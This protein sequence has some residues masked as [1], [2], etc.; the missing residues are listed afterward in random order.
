MKHQIVVIHG[1]DSFD[2]YE[3]YLKFLKDW[4]IDFEEYRNPESGWKKNL[5]KDLGPDFEVIMPNMPNEINAKYLEWKIWFEKFI[6]YFEKE[7]V[8]I[9]HSQGGI[10]LAKYLSENKFS[11]KIVATFLVAAP[12]DDKESDY[13]LADFKLTKSLVKLEEQGG[14]IFIYHS[15]DDK[16]VSFADFAGY[17][18]ELKNATIRVFKDRGHFNQEKLPEIIKDI[19]SICLKK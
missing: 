19:K 6:P 2:T 13:S 18:K 10:F 17:K 5:A 12:Y 7:V 16:V 11:K 4:R 15:E 14:Q 3:E 8:L 1:G 9:G